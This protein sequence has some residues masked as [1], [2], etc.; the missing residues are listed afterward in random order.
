MTEYSRASRHALPPNQDPT[1]AYFIHP[2]DAN[3]TQLDSVKFKFNGNGFRNW[4]RSMI[5][6]LSAKNKLGF[7]DESIEKPD[8]TSVEH[9]AWERCNDLVSSWIIFNLED[10]IAKSVL[11]LKTAKD[12]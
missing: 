10:V 4:K 12:I 5:L 2:S 6:S 7:V 1:S 8:V 9:K 11:F 3:S